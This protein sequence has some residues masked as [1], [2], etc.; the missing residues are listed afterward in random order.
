MGEKRKQERDLEHKLANAGKDDPDWIW[1]NQMP[2]ASG[3]VGHRADRTRAIDLVCKRKVAP[4][5]YRFIELKISRSAGAP[6]AAL[7]EIFRYGVVYFVLRKNQK[8]EWLKGVQL[9]SPIFKASHIDL[10]VLA[11]K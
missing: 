8:V 4:F 11:P 5:C 6:L 9:D 2:I 7:M 1:W 10:C 3:L